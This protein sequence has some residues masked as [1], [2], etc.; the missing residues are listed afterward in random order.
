[1]PFHRRI[2]EATYSLIAVLFFLAWLRETA[3]LRPLRDRPSSGSLPWGDERLPQLLRAS[4]NG[5]LHAALPSP[6]QHTKTKLS[7]EVLMPRLFIAS[8]NRSLNAFKKE[9]N[10]SQLFLRRDGNDPNPYSR[11]NITGTYRGSWRIQDRSMQFLLPDTG[12][13]INLSHFIRIRCTTRLPGTEL[14]HFACK[15]R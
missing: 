4:S 3:A 8:N 2:F 11:W 10:P 1:M 9:D 6:I 12:F 13:E 15:R 5:S 7:L 14:E